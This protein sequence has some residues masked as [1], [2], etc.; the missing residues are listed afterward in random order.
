MPKR[1]TSPKPSESVQPDLITLLTQSNFLFRGLDPQWLATY[2]PPQSLTLEKLYSSRPVYMAF[3]PGE[4]LDVLYVLISGG[5]VILR[6]T[7]L[8]RIIGMTYAGSCFGMFDLPLGGGAVGR[9]FPSL[10]EAYKMADIVKVPLAALQDIYTESAPFRERYNQLLE[11]REKFQYH[12]LNCSTYPPQAV[13]ALLR[14]LVYQERAL[15]QMPNAD[16]VFVFDLPVE[17]IALACQLN[18]RTVEQVLKGM[19]QV[20]L[21]QVIE[22]DLVC[23]LDPEGLKAVYSATRDKVSW[24]PLR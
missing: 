15:G 17:I 13:A 22:D 16:G 4:L 12:L 10:V 21:V 8:D 18:H 2:L 19:V 3:Q 24:W 20:G 11:L 1:S 9:A 14:A 5:P 6:S 23:V 7:P